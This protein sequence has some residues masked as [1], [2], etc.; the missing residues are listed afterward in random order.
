MAFRE[1]GN[2][3]STRKVVIDPRIS[4][5][6]GKIKRAIP[7]VTYGTSFSTNPQVGDF[8]YF[9]GE[10]TGEFTK[11]NWYLAKPENKGWQSI[12]AQAVAGGSISGAIPSGVTI[13]DYLSK[14]G[15]TLEGAI[16]FYKDQVI[17]AE[18]LTGAIPPGVTIQDYLGIY[19][20]TMLGPII[21]A[22]SSLTRVGTITGY[23]KDIKI[24]MNN[25]GTLTLEADTEATL[26]AALIS[27]T[28]AVAIS[29]TLQFVLGTSINEFSID[30]T[31]A[32][33]SDDAVPTE[34]AVKTYADTQRDSVVCDLW[35]VT[36]HEGDIIYAIPNF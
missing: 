36:T 25:D 2:V 34:Q 18:M 13:E 20:G 33:N 7:R 6:I 17:P 30:G 16:E 26:Q 29:A 31:L 35:G 22:G 12:N 15:G 9:T 32:G 8:H 1:R 21:M 5:E 10:S 4:Y 28:G 3:G 23:D 19:G 14:F 11:N 27:L 24:T